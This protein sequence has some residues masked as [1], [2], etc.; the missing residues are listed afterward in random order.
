M[1]ASVKAAAIGICLKY[2]VQMVNFF[3]SENH[4][5]DAEAGGGI[6]TI[7][8]IWDR[9][10]WKSLI[11]VDSSKPNVTTENLFK[12]YPVLD[13]RYI[14]LFAWFGNQYQE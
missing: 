7:C 5:I 9:M 8:Y 12:S 6:S 1:E 11:R 4:N 10:W 2:K 13:Y 14:G 3:Y